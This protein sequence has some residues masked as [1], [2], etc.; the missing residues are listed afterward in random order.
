MMMTFSPIITPE[1]MWTFSMTFAL[2]AIWAGCLS[3]K[4][5]LA[6]N[7]EILA[8]SKCGFLL[9]I[10]WFFTKLACSWRTKIAPAFELSKSLTFASPSQY[11]SSL[12]PAFFSE[13]RPE[14]SSSY[15]AG[16]FC[17]KILYILLKSITTP[18]S[19][20]LSARFD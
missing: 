20:T 10:A 17:P 9:I 3:S 12:A 6:K 18:S 4:S 14:M 19:L 11:E 8:K 7:A 16:W 5:G 2:L 13:F 15:P 1:P